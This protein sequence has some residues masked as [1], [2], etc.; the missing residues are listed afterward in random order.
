MNPITFKLGGVPEH[1]NLPWHQAMEQG[2]FQEQGIQ[3]NWQDYPGG[4]GAM[5]KDLRSGDLDLAVLLTEGMVADIVKGNKS[6]IIS[7]YVASPLIWGI[8]VPANSNLQEVNQLADKR[9]A[10]SRMGSGSHLMAFVNAQQQGWD[11]N[12]MELVLVGDING[13]RQAFQNNEADVFMWEKFM[14]KPLVDS[15]EFR[16]V[17][18]CPTPWPCFVIAARQEIINKYTPELQQLLAVIHQ[19]NQAFMQNPQAPQ[20]VA[21]KF[22]L[23]PEDAATWFNHTRW[24]TEATVPLDM[25]ETVIDTLHSLDL[26]PEKPE[27][28]SL[29]ANLTGVQQS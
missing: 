24:A 17:G 7:V 5:A 10:I 21:E 27:A 1:F 12:N 28:A 2:L 16:R 19:A 29:V 6:K 20:L 11:P 8:H 3:I 4:T 25:V 26:I 9:Y 23:K 18:E 15:G 22:N 13:A 14:T